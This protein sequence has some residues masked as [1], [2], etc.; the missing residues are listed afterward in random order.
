MRR[1]LVAGKTRLN[2]QQGFTLFELLLVLLVIGIMTASV[3]LSGGIVRQDRQLRSESERIQALLELACEE[4][5][6][7]NQMVGAL[8]DKSS[9]SFMS[10]TG[11]LWQVYGE[12][13]TL[14]PQIL[15]DQILRHL[16]QN[17]QQLELTQQDNT[18]KP[19]ILCFSNGTISEFELTFLQAQQ[20]AHLSSDG[21]HLKLEMRGDAE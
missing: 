16:T 4:A 7:R 3:V 19:Q 18:L 21:R 20:Q 8:F 2:I 9:L 6:M 5:V 15:S 13:D 10:W 12:Q 1:I 14:H 11:D 17:G